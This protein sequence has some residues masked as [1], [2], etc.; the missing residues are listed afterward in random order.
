LFHSSN[1]LGTQQLNTMKTST[2]ISIPVTD[3]TPKQWTHET[4]HPATTSARWEFRIDG[5]PSGLSADRAWISFLR[6]RDVIV[7]EAL[8]V[9]GEKILG[10]SRSVLAVDWKN[11]NRHQKNV[12][13]RLHFLKTLIESRSNQTGSV[14]D[15]PTRRSRLSWFARGLWFLRKVMAKVE[16]VLWSEKWQIEISNT[17]KRWILEGDGKNF[18]ADTFPVVEAGRQYVFYENYLDDKKKG[19]LEAREFRPD[20]GFGPSFPVLETP[21]HLSYPYVWSFEGEWFM[22]PETSQNRTVDLYKALEFPHRWTLVKTLLPDIRAVDS[23]LLFYQGRWWLFASVADDARGSTTDS[24]HLFFT[25]D[26][27]T[28]KWTP[29]PLNPIVQDVRSARPA[30]R[31]FI[32]DGKLYRPAQDCSVRYGYAVRIQEV[33]ELT[34]STY[35][36]R[37]GEVLRPR[38][39]TFGIH[40]YNTEGG[41]TFADSIVRKRK[42]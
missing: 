11:W 23:S 18:V 31:P 19:V 4:L 14:T 25:D 35:Q 5:K 38:S 42:S 37:D 1:A 7:C 41:W 39:G 40:T 10:S 3:S 36:E 16:S 20:S 32:R 21:Y 34:E 15:A 12:S 22:V 8:L 27:R 33:L 28:G 26:F 6:L 9:D 30:G 24:L 29:H 2:T 17:E 13:L